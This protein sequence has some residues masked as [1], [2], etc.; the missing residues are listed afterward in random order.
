MVGFRKLM[1]IF[2][3]F[4][5]AGV[6]QFT[7]ISY[8]ILGHYFVELVQYNQ[9]CCIKSIRKYQHFRLR[10]DESSS[11][12]QQH[13][14]DD[15]KSCSFQQP[16]CDFTYKYRTFDGS[17]NNLKYPE[18][19]MANTVYGRM[20]IPNYGDGIS[21]PRIAIDGTSLP[22]ARTLST[23][24][25][26]EA[27]NADE[28]TSLALMQWGQFIAH[29]VAFT[30]DRDGAPIDCCNSNELEDVNTCFPID[31]PA[32]D[33]F[34]SQFNVTCRNMQR[35]KFILLKNCS[36]TAEQING[37]SHFMDGSQIY[38]SSSDIARSL[39]TFKDGRLL[40]QTCE[41]GKSFLPP[42]TPADACNNMNSINYLTGDSR[43]NQNPQLAVLHTVFAR[44]HNR[45]ATELLRLH[46]GWNDEVLYQEA[47]AIVIAELHQITYNE[48]LPLLLGKAYMAYHNLYSN[49]RRN[50]T[51]NSNLVPVGTIDFASAFRVGHSA[52]QGQINIVSN[53]HT[54]P[55]KRLNL[56]DYLNRPGVIQ[57]AACF[58]DFLRSLLQQPMQKVDEFCSSQITQMLFH[59]SNSFGDDLISVDIQRGREHGLPSY[60]EYLYTCTNNRPRSFLDLKNIIKARFIPLLEKL[61]TSVDDIDL[62][63][64]GNLEYHAPG[65]RL[66]PTFQCIIG[67]QFYRYKY[68]DRFWY[69]IRGQQH[70][71]SNGQLYEIKKVTLSRIIC[72]N[73]NINVVSPNSFLLPSIRNNI[74]SCEQIPRMNL[75]RW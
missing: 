54:C 25:F 43:V 30:A 73:S 65:S 2:Y 7:F 53:I 47:R 42:T 13:V 57:Q 66:G 27:N 45:I 16:T 52:I 9:L 39:R 48:W 14:S 17:C 64:G 3:F 23:T 50:Y 26:H 68:G 8:Y 21:L 10:N 40:V 35:K 5:T 55:M 44:E 37:V 58:D 67:E 51:Y 18:W 46:P 36:R 60:V 63:V 28:I 6:N 38:G 74:I 19:G 56:S 49:N 75:N 22:L 4:A 15:Y 41:P 62:F 61:Y 32:D 1:K 71:F 70:S 72:D 33:L 12:N 20:L 29:D 59:G 11:S 34:Y 31:I 69:E 24:F